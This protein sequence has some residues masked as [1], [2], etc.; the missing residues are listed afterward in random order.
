MVRIISAYLLFLILISACKENGKKQAPVSKGS[1]YEQGLALMQQARSIKDSAK[2]EGILNQAIP[3][4]EKVYFTDSANANN[5]YLLG[6]AYYMRRDFQKAVF[7]YYAH[8]KLKPEFTDIDKNIFASY[9]ELGRKYQ[10]MDNNPLHAKRSLV[11]AD[12]IRPND[13]ETLELLGIAECSLSNF[14]EGKAYYARVLKID[15][16][17]ASTYFNYSLVFAKEGDF[18]KCQSYLD[19]ANAIKPGFINPYL[20]RHKKGLPIYPREGP[21]QPGSH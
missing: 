1:P 11:I 4:L 9:R 17:R 3:L 18:K 10:F 13:I 7:M 14:D 19:K 15:P 2:R 6:N 20:E 8:K 21:P 12:S 5:I 16:N